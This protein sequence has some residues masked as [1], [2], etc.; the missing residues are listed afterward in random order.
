LWLVTLTC[1]SQAAFEIS[2]STKEDDFVNRSAIDHDGNVI[3]TGSVGNVVDLITSAFVIKVFPDGTFINR[4]FDRPDTISSFNS[5]TI[6]D[7]G[8]YFITG[9]YSAGGSF[10]TMD[11]FWVI[12]LDNNL[13]TVLEK[14]YGINDPYLKY[15]GINSSIINQEGDVVIAAINER[16]IMNV[17]RPD[18]I[19]FKFNQQGDSISSRQYESFPSSRPNSLSRI[20]D[21]D[22]LIMIGRG[23]LE[24]GSESMIFMDNNMN[25]SHSIGFSET[26]DVSERMRYSNGNWLS[27]TE[28]LMV[29]D[30][31][32]DLDR[33][34]EYYFSVSRMNTSGQY[35]GEL[36]LDR[37]DTL[38]YHAIGK[39][40]VIAI[41]SLIYVAG[42]QS[43]NDLW[44][45]T[46]SVPIIYLIDKNLNL[47][48]RKNLGGDAYYSLV[49]IEATLDN[50]VLAYGTRYIN[51]GSFARDIHIWKLL[52]EDFEI[53]TE[54]I[55]KPAAA[56]EH[57]VWPNPARDVLHIS[58]EGLQTG[59]DFRLSIYN[60]AGQKYFDK[61][62][63][64]TAKALQC[65]IGVLPSGTYVYEI[66]TAAGQVGS[67]KF[68][69]K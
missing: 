29:A 38:E 43:Y 37:P 51:A 65:H 64:A 45:T 10:Y 47:L 36:H 24:S 12:I 26:S 9:S 5:I 27:A 66:Q 11:Q 68:I 57:K 17:Q 61:A 23:Y 14:N 56:I 2:I 30:R 52:R 1:F 41:D 69:K 67:G 46:P 33:Y 50:G 22:S 62:F 18:F 44:T 4:K 20:P 35:L 25:F 54:L 19:M 42:R 63:K 59:S 55:D 58:L 21:T 8:N 7:N 40:L 39:N 13:E 34:R 6:L 31:L 53:I 15:G 28:F 16:L 60:T 3:L 32:V 49:G 48:G